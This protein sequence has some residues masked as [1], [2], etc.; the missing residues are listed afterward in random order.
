VTFSAGR[1]VTVASRSGWHGKCERDAKA[2]YLTVFLTIS[3]GGTV[4][5]QRGRGGDVEAEKPRLLYYCTSCETR[6]HTV[7]QGTCPTCGSQAIVSVGW[8]RRSLDER[9][10]WFQRIRGEHRNSSH[11]ATGD[12][13]RLKKTNKTEE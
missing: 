5:I 12:R 13:E 2:P 7:S 1:S 11:E 4:G 10:E 9:K 3:F 8:Y 6:H